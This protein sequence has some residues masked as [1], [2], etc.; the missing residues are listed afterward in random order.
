MIQI[1]GVDCV[2]LKEY[3]LLSSEQYHHTLVTKLLDI[4]ETS[5]RSENCV[6]LVTMAMCIKLL[7]QIL[8]LSKEVILI[9]EH[10]AQLEVF[11]YCTL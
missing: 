5:T 2:L 1:V 9:D 3:Q 11:G 6:R 7:Q 8:D 10:L 4:L